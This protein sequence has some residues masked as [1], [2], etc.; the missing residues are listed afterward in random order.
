MAA[1]KYVPGY[2]IGRWTVTSRDGPKH[3]LARCDCGTERRLQV[4]NI[5]SG[6]SQSCGC[7][8]RQIVTSHGE[9]KTRLYHIW[10]SMKHRARRRDTHRHATVCEDWQC[11]ENFR[12]WSLESGY[13]DT[14]TIDR[15]NNDLGYSPDNCRWTTQSVQMVN[16]RK[17]PERSSQYL[18]VCWDASRH[19]WKAAVRFNGGHKNIGRFDNEEEAARARDKAAIQIQGEY[20]ILNFPEEAQQSGKEET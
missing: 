5:A 14:L 3:V 6:R 18:G 11:F 19:R 7:L 10:R 15:I 17:R 8:M 2:R 9:T 16:R 1:I 4:G 20:A 12:A 13:D